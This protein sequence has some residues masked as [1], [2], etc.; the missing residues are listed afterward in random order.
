MI[1]TGAYR[2]SNS[3][4][5]FLDDQVVEGEAPENLSPKAGLMTLYL[6]TY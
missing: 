3:A 4:G 1:P 5:F 6:S 2:R